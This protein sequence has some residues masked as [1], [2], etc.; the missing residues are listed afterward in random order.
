VL[1]ENLAL[2]RPIML[3]VTDADSIVAAVTELDAAVGEDGLFALVNNAGIAISGPTEALDLND[4]RRVIEVNFFGAVAVT[5]AMLPLLRRAKR[6]RIV[7]ISSSYGSVSIP[8]A[9]P[10]CASKHA[11][12]S[13]SQ[14]LRLELHGSLSVIVVAP[15][16]VQ[17]PIWDKAE[18]QLVET[19]SQ[20]SDDH[21]RRYGRRLSVLSHRAIEAGHHGLEAKRVA[22]AVH[23][24]LLARRPKPRYTVGAFARWCSIAARFLPQRVADWLVRQS[25][26]VDGPAIRPVLHHR[27]G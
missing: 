5:R 27:T 6:A 22:R 1:N 17:T 13:F 10:Y 4:W 8:F 12:E 18:H 15:S 19:I 26:K 7:N 21:Q 3:D 9:G 14:A 23:R 25:T 16:D 24:V 2:L 11:L 20:L